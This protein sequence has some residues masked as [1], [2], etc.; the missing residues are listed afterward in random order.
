MKKMKLFLVAAVV[1]GSASAFTTK[2]ETLNDPLFV[3]NRTQT[4]YVE[5]TPEIEGEGQC[6]TGQVS[7]T[8][9]DQSGTPN[10]ADAEKVWIYN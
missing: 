3:P 1:L 5:L 4:G 10:P 2:S 9:L 6:M 8:F 7:C